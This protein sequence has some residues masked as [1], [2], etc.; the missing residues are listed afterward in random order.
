MDPCPA[1][2]VLLVSATHDGTSHG[3]H[4]WYPDD[5]NQNANDGIDNNVLEGA[6]SKSL[7][8][9]RAQKSDGVQGYNRPN[10]ANATTKLGSLT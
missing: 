2:P 3:P 7:Q 10:V 6:F 8:F 4:H 9:D 5:G 1:E